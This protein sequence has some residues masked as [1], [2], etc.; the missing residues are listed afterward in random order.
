MLRIEKELEEARGR[1][2]A[3]RQAKYKLRTGETSGEETDTDVYIGGYT[4]DSSAH[5]Q[6]RYK[7]YYNLLFVRAKLKLRIIRH[8]CKS[9][10]L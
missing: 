6:H 10:I 4:S 2:N 1:L 9:A 5:Q 8:L 7:A 3:I